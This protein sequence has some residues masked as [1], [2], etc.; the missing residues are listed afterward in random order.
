MHE[1]FQ[2]SWLSSWQF[3]GECKSE[4][5]LKV[6]VRGAAAAAVRGGRSLGQQ[7]GWSLEAALTAA[8]GRKHIKRTLRML[9]NEPISYIYY[10]SFD[11]FAH[12]II[13]IRSKSLL[14]SWGDTFLSD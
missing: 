11:D 1:I 4:S 13:I 3:L 6:G 10:I 8:F 2:F 9:H 7:G 5:R 12:Q 14:E